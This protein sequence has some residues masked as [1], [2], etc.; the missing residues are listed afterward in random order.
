MKNIKM[1]K[2]KMKKK[3]FEKEENFKNNNNNNN[4]FDDDDYFYDT[5]NLQASAVSKHE[6]NDVPAPQETPKKNP[7]HHT[8]YI[9]NLPKDITVQELQKLFGSIGMIK[10]DKDKN[11]NKIRIYK[12]NDGV[13]KGDATIRYDE[14]QAAK[15][16]IEWFNGYDV[17]GHKISVEFAL[18]RE[19]TFQNSKKGKGGAKNKAEE[20]WKCA[21]CGEKNWIK[22]TMCKNCKEERPQDVVQSLP[23]PPVMN[24]GDWICV[25]CGNVNWARRSACNKCKLQKDK[26]PNDENKAYGAERKSNKRQSNNP[27]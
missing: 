26:D 18:Q 16:A 10:L 7:E 6:Y 21:N 23:K 8:I 9:T 3:N 15:A 19:S 2:I 13:G 20:D 17:N 14:P 4:N 25:S 5:S 11:E 22:R 27:Y 1:K 12:D 24:E